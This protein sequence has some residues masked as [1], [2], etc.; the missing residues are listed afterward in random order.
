MKFLDLLYKLVFVNQDC[1]QV[2]FFNLFD[3]VFLE[4]ARIS[5][6]VAYFT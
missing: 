2:T 6:C 4:F 3:F 1:D 5:K